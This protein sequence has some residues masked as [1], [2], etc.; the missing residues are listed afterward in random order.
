MKINILWTRQERTKFRTKVQ[1]QLIKTLHDHYVV[2]VNTGPQD[3]DDVE[4]TVDTSSHALDV[5][6]N[7]V[8]MGPHALNNGP[9]A[10]HC[11]D[12]ATDKLNSQ[13]GHVDGL[14]GALTARSILNVSFLEV[15][16]KAATRAY[17]PATTSV[18]KSKPPASS[19]GEQ[20]NKPNE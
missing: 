20:A 5:V 16:S 19:P 6:N 11:V 18:H 8:H 9:H 4:D 1:L 2:V 17:M 10:V 12:Q 15:T 3:C 7:T 14:G 13:V